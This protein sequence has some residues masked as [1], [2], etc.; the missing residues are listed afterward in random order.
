MQAIR[1]AVPQAI[2]ITRMRDTIPSFLANDEGTLISG[3]IPQLGLY[4]RPQNALF[5]QLHAVPVAV[6]Q[7]AGFGNL[8]R[9][10]TDRQRLTNLLG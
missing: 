9:A 4:T 1:A 10:G 7:H 8:H 6:V 2:K 3:Q 5:Q